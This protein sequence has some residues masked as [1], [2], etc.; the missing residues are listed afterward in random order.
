MGSIR[1]VQSSIHQ[2]L[3]YKGDN[4]STQAFLIFV[5]NNNLQHMINSA[6]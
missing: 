4:I 3:L 1:N 5:E 2:Y 6:E